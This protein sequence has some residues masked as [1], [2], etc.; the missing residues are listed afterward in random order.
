M[1]AVH[2]GQRGRGS[3]AF[4]RPNFRPEFTERNFAHRKEIQRHKTGA[5]KATRELDCPPDF[6]E[7]NFVSFKINGLTGESTSHV[8]MTRDGFTF[9]AMGFTGAKAAAW[10]VDGARRGAREC[11]DAGRVPRRAP[12]CVPVHR[13]VS[14][15]IV[16]ASRERFQ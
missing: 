16:D 3:H 6:E 5:A 1:R 13:R 14:R 8:E 4:N 12:P 7:R 10:K 2:R 15:R 9:L 11:C